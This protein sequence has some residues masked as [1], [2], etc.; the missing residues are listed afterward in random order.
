[1]KKKFLAIALLAGTM[2]L[3][4]TAFTGCNKST[5]YSETFEG[6][7]SESTYD[8]KDDAAKGFLE[9]ELSVGSTKAELTAYNKEKDLSESEIEKLKISTQVDGTISSVEKGKI[10]YTQTEAQVPFAA[11]QDSQEEVLVVTVYIITYTSTGST[12]VTYKYYA[13]LPEKGEALSASYYNSVLGGNQ[14]ENCTVTATSTTTSSYAGASAKITLKYVMAIDNDKASLKFD[15][16]VS[17][18][19]VNTKVSMSFYL[20]DTATGLKCALLED[21]GYV[22]SSLD[23]A[24][25][26]IE[27]VSELYSSQLTEAECALFVKTDY[28]FELK[29]GVLENLIGEAGSSS[30]KGTCK[31][32]VA[33]GKID[34]A[35]CD[36]SMKLTSPEGTMNM[37][38]NVDCKFSNYGT[39][40][41]NLPDQVKT[42]FGIED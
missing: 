31:Y 3:G 35:V 6:V 25:L 36:Y 27:S 21:N 9:E 29:E 24:E 11:A 13:P 39:T 17:A 32:Y 33:E 42:L 8:S 2:A 16:G 18:P 7:V 30:F 38:G 12:T 28:G 22:L 34:K 14:Y 40:T 1:M 41:V 4:A 15:M 20:A 37:S 5:N 23:D 19:G 26:Y 10:S